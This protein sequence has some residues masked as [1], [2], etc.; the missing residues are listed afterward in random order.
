MF[1]KEVDLILRVG[2]EIPETFA[3]SASNSFFYKQKKCDYKVG[4]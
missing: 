4:S 3:S 1:F 2:L